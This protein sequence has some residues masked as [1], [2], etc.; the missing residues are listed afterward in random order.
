ML[1]YRIAH[2]L[3]FITLSCPNYPIPFE[4][5]DKRFPFEIVESDSTLQELAGQIHPKSNLVFQTEYCLSVF[6]AMSPHLIR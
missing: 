2:L 1:F 3:V 4:I 6:R 5:A